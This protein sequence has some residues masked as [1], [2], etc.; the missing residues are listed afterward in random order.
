MWQTIA[1]IILKNR[2]FVLLL[3]GVVTVF[4]GHR[5][6]K[7]EVRYDFASLLPPD[8]P[9]LV[10]YTDFKQR[11]GEDGAMMVIGIQ[12]PEMFTIEVFNA[13]YDLGQ[14]VKALPG[15]DQ[16]ISVARCMNISRNDS[17][18]KFDF[19]PLVSHRPTEQAQVDSIRTVLE[20]LPF[21]KDV[22]WNG[23]EMAFVMA[24]TMSP[25]YLDS[26]RRIELSERVR[27]IAHSYEERLNAPLHI[28]GLPFIR[29]SIAQMV[30]S[31]LRLFIFLAAAVTG[32]IMFLFF[33]S[34]TV[35]FFSLLVVAI[36][37]VWGFGIISLLGY[38]LSILTGLIPPLLIVLGIAN[39]IFLLNKY[40]SEFRDHGNKIKALQ[41]MVRKVGNATLLTNATTATGFVTFAILESAVMREFGIVASLSIMG[42]FLVSLLLIPVVFSYLPQPRHRHIRHLD[43]KTSLVIITRI[44]Q[45]VQS[46]R[47]KIYGV[48]LVMLAFGFYGITKVRTTG[49][50]VDDLPKDNPVL[51]D[52]RWFE[53]HF[54]GVM[55]FE[56]RIDALKPDK[57]VS[58]ATL[59]RISQL[60]DELATHSEFAR[61][62]S[63]VE[64]IKFI[65]Q[66]YYGGLAEKYDLPSNSERGFILSYGQG[67]EEG[68]GLLHTFIDSARQQTRLSVQMRDV[69]TEEM[70]RLLAE[71]RP[72]VDS[73]FPDDR[74]DVLLTGTSVVFLKGT[75]YLVNNLF[76]SLGIAILIIALIMLRMFRSWRMVVVSLVPNLFPLVIT[77]AL[78][79]YF[80]ITI[81]PSTILV[82][83]IALG[84]SVDDTIHF[85]AK[86][87]QELEITGWSIRRSVMKA[88][89][90]VGVSMIYTSVVLFCGFAIFA[91]S[92][93]GG[94]KALGLL[95]SITLFVA[96][97]S[98]LLILPALLLTFERS[99]TTRDFQVA[100]K[101]E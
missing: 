64:V 50:L 28:S 68:T 19:L 97:F 25:D 75:E 26:R 30:Q 51:T 9:D 2:P 39:C 35:V 15:I 13:W 66:G 10:A 48:A 80:G 77:A 23:E 81:K 83:S 40:H 72:K 71:I 74:Y 8:D 95:I 32:L 38:K 85:L 63:I 92:T 61:A 3:I 20:Q 87:R 44:I 27:T 33:R 90:E 89:R 12:Q 99:L 94:T 14:E 54:G 36:A 93:F 1:R 91:A 82:F 67:E 52:L 57:A 65:K 86:Y 4:M 70:V 42:I 88:L 78:M 53:E 16:V 76:V 49:N 7:V 58:A 37:V 17:L 22:L 24:I 84:I 79:G 5:A 101:E 59:R 18:K 41:R 73:I 43:R 60:Q 45:V 31:E 100:D 6:T 21:Y 69:G 47:T 46:H 62:V 11:F 29:S 55:P 98:N 96:M 34:F 56:V